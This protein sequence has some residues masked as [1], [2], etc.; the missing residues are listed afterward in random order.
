[1]Q[2]K[3]AKWQIGLE[4]KATGSGGDFLLGQPDFFMGYKYLGMSTLCEANQP[5]AGRP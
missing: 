5:R 2:L 1:M 4:Q 3:W